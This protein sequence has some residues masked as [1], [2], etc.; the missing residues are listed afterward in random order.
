[1]RPSPQSRF[2]TLS[3]ALGLAALPFGSCGIVDPRAPYRFSEMDYA[4]TP[5]ASIDPPPADLSLVVFARPGLD[6]PMSA[7]LVY[8]GDKPAAMLSAG[9]WASYLTRPGERVF[10]SAA[11]DHDPQFLRAR[12]M[13]G[14][15]YVVHVALIYRNDV[16]SYGLIPLRPGS[17]ELADMKALLPACTHVEMS[18]SAREWDADNRATIIAPLRARYDKWLLGEGKDRAVMD[19]PYGLTVL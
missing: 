3:L 13:P 9:T 5:G 4:E 6:L 2:F 15:I 12:L 19:E 11:M 18:S 14:R 10:M 17:P 7:T 1:M 8:D 16:F